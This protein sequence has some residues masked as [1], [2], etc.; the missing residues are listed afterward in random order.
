MKKHNHLAI[1]QFSHNLKNGFGLL[2][3]LISVGILALVVGGVVG[4]GNISVKNSVISADRT[5]AYNLAQEGKEELKQIR[6]SKWVDGSSSATIPWNEEFKTDGSN[7]QLEQD[8]ATKKFYLAPGSKSILLNG[9]T[10]TRFVTFSA[11]D[12]DTQANLLSQTPVIDN[13]NKEWMIKATI[14]V[15][16]TEYDK[17]WTV[18]LPAYFTDWMPL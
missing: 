4:L 3:V 12:A 1:K 2:E 15:S 11:P 8:A 16:W 5:V 7:Y 18:I 9:T 10:Y 6:D 13:A 14:T 17:N